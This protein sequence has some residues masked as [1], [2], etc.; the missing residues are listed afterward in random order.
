MTF[1]DSLSQGYTAFVQFYDGEICW[2]KHSDS[3]NGGKQGKQKLCSL[4]WNWGYFSTYPQTNSDLA[5]YK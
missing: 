4:E 1:Y 5:V 2:V 3:E